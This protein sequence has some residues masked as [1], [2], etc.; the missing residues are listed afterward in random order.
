MQTRTTVMC[1]KRNTEEIA[2]KNID[3]FDNKEMIAH[4]KTKRSI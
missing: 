3:K 2:D 1:I 4:I